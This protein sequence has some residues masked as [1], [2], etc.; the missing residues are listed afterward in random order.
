M[1]RGGRGIGWTFE[2]GRGRREGDW[3]VSGEI[4]TV[5]SWGVGRVE[6]LNFWVIVDVSADADAN[7]D[8]SERVDLYN[9]E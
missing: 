1:K 2:V 7:D 3:I 5:G 9:F 4:W 6:V 8:A